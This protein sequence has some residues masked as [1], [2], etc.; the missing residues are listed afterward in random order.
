ME[1]GVLVVVM[2][3]SLIGPSA[4]APGLGRASP[5][6]A[7]EGSIT[8]RRASGG[9]LPLLVLIR[10]YRLPLPIH[11]QLQAS[12]RFIALQFPPRLLD[13]PTQVAH[14]D[15]HHGSSPS[16]SSLTVSQPRCWPCGE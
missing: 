2:V 13:N 11:V 6:T 7:G 5:T 8:P 16:P 3:V 10:R 1:H 14:L 4:F 15:R 9:Q 12:I